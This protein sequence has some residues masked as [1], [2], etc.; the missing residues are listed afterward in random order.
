MKDSYRRN[1]QKKILLLGG[2]HGQLPAIEE[3]K[4]RGL[5]TILCDYLPDNPGRNF[6]D[7]YFEVST[8]DKA[9]ILEIAEKHQV[10]AVFAYA[11]DP[12]T[13]TAAYVSEKLNLIGNTLQSINVLS[14]KNGFRNL[15]KNAHFN[16]PWFQTFQEDH[17]ESIKKNTFKFPV[18]VKPV[19]SSDTKG[20]FIV[21][22]RK[23]LHEKAKESITFSRVKTIIVEEFVNAELGNLHGDAFFVDG[24]MVFC[25]LGDRLFSSESNPL[26]PSTELYPSSLPRNIIAK[27][28]DE[29]AAVVKK[30]GF[31]QGPVNVEARVDKFGKI[32]IMEIGPR[33]GGTL[34]PQTIKYSTGFDMLKASVDQIL[35]I[36]IS[37]S[38]KKITP[39][40]CYALHTNCTGI[41]QRLELPPK[42]N[43]YLK[44]K[45]IYV[46]SGDLVKPYSE[47]GSTI[48]VCIFSFPDLGIAENVIKGLYEIL[49]SS[50]RLKDVVAEFGN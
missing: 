25:M 31:K 45:H 29:V 24:E 5:T 21:F 42:L 20:V 44:E 28:E 40:V 35:N 18:V 33:S 2:S 6:A 8:T 34:T 16:T 50:V 27:V 47:P 48:G 1:T 7:I 14:N 49:Q 26:K 22:D 13:P 12:A 17:I 9:A 38:T 3:A 15:Q 39:S 32:T 11:S 30:S 36:P 43:R 10:D 23:S 37:I 41:F 19:D 4:R 46:S